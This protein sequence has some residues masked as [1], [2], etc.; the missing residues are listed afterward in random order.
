[1]A[2]S[3]LCSIAPGQRFTADIG[4]FAMVLTGD[5]NGDVQAWIDNSQVERLF[6]EGVISSPSA[7]VIP[8][9]VAGSVII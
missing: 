4:G 1:M 6:K 2:A 7:P 8:A 5:F 9:P 3:T